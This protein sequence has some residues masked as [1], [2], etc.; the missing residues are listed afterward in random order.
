MTSRLVMPSKLVDNIANVEPD[1]FR[2]IDEFNHIDP[3]VSIFNVGDERLMP[4]HRLRHFGLGQARSKTLL[5]EQLGKSP[6]SRRMKRLGH[7]RDSWV[8]LRANPIFRLSKNQILFASALV[9]ATCSQS[10]DT[11]GRLR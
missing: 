1:D 4:P 8:V 5:Q 9:C 3:P 10:G 11:R 7:T 6:M 2:Q